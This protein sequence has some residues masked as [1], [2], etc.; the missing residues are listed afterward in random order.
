MTERVL[1]TGITGYIGQHCAAELLRQGYEVVGTVRSRSK[2]DATEAALAQAAPVD[3]LSFADADLLSDEGWDDAMKGC[4]FVVHVAS[5]FVTAEPKDENELIAPAVEGTKRVVAAAQR[6]G[7]KRLVL[8]SSTFAVIAGK[9]SGTYGPDSWSDTGGAIGA[10]AK[11]KTL[12]ERAAWKA[13]EG[14]TMEMVAIC[15]GPVFGPSLG[16]KIDGQSAALIRDMISGKVPMIPDVAMGMI[17]V[18]DVARLHVK[19]LTAVGAAGKRFIAASAEPVEMATLASVLRGAGYSK[20]PSRRAPSFLLR[21]M[22]V[23]DREARGMVPF[24]GKKAAFDSRATFELLDWK[25]T[26]IERSLTEMAAA[27]SA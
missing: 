3:R 27:L 22:G 1:L 15:P 10:Y 6:A 13:A 18:R 21:F 23:F 19:A 16:A 25:P 26:P 11:S 4:T 17:D 5:P 24:L 7:V 12:A 20:V 8:T 9:D 2:A 14:G